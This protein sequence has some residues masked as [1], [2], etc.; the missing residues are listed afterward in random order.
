MEIE[1]NDQNSAVAIKY[2]RGVIEL[3]EVAIKHGDIARINILFSF[4]QID[5]T[6]EE[7]R[8]SLADWRLA[9]GNKVYKPNDTSTYALKVPD[10]C[11]QLIIYPDTKNI[12]AAFVLSLIGTFPFILKTEETFGP[13][14]IVTDENADA[15]ENDDEYEYPYDPTEND[16][17]IRED[18]QTIFELMRK[19]DQGKL[20]IDPDFQRKLVWKPIQ[21]SRFIESVILNFPLPPFYV[22]QTNEGKY[23]I[24]DGLQRTTTLHSFINNK[25]ALS[26][27]EALPHLN[28]KTFDELKL[29]AGDFQ[30]KIEDKKLTLYTI[31]PSVKPRVIYDI[32]NRINTNGTPLNRQEVRNC[33]FIGKS[34]KLLKVLS[35]SEL[36]KSS[37]DNGVSPQRMKDREIILRFLAFKILDRKVDYKG[38]LSDFVEQCMLVINKMHESKI[39]EITEEFYRVMGLTLDFFGKNNYRLPVNGK[40]GLI[41][42]AIFESVSYFFSVNSTDYLRKN[43]SAIV[44]NYNA[45]LNNSKYIDSVRVSTNAIHRVETRFTLVPEILNINCTQ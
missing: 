28:D 24:V 21:S 23:I 16:L 26:G 6:R 5:N 41:N 7:Q 18:P 37:I 39:H 22:N 1:F 36:F 9:P 2:P 10:N 27:L 30:T 15:S 38:D 8:I 35:E 32:F 20:I 33:I 25:F 3:T 40:R 17:D 4:I 11:E 31:R 13:D 14:L 43:K 19:Y 34:T 12:A 45:L 29:L 42:T 44:N